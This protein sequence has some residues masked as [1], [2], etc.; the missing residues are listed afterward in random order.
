MGAVATQ[1]NW[2]V[3]GLVPYPP[4]P[5]PESPGLPGIVSLLELL[6]PFSRDILNLR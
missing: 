6:V 4:L 3:I 1:I 2:L 5:S